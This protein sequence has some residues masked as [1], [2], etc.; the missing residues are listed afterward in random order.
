VQVIFLSNKEKKSFHLCNTTRSRILNKRLQPNAQS[1][2]SKLCVHK[3]LIRNL[4]SPH[5]KKITNKTTSTSCFFFFFFFNHTV[6]SLSS[7]TQASQNPEVFFPPSK[8][9]TKTSQKNFLRTPKRIP[10]LRNQKELQPR[11]VP[12]SLP[13][14]LLSFRKNIPLRA[15][16]TKSLLPHKTTC[17]RALASFFPRRA[18]SPDQQYTKRHSFYLPVFFSTSTL[19]KKNLSPHSPPI[20]PT[21]KISDRKSV[22]WKASVYK[23]SLPWASCPFLPSFCQPNNR[24]KDIPFIYQFFFPSTQEKKPSLTHLH[25]IRPTYKISDRKSIDWES[26][27]SPMHKQSA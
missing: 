1:C 13:L 6:F 26:L 4:T 12:I 18:G 10:K 9:E 24:L 17:P 22:A 7:T 11:S 15:D 2:T 20:R 8:P 14:L 23:P 27:E 3:S 16:I 21:C 25:P 19:E 5:T